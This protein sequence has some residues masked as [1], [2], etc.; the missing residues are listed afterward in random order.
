[1]TF[2]IG[3]F[4]YS[5]QNYV[6]QP[7]G[8]EETAT[9]QGL[10]ARKV[11][12]SVLLSAADWLDLT[13]EY[14]NWR[15]LRIEDPDSKTSLDVGTTIGVSLSANGL[16]WSN[17]PCWFIQ[18]PAGEQVGAYVQ[19][20]VELVDADQALQVAIKEDLLSRSRYYFGTYTLGGVTLNLL[21]P[22]ET[23]QDTPQVS[24]TASGTSYITGA[25]IATRV[26]QLEGDTDSQGWIDIRDW[27]ESTVVLYPSVGDWFPI[28]APSATAEPDIVAGVRVDRYTVSVSLAQVI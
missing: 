22:P 8:Y 10:T 15:D 16:S 24:L 27:Y 14:D 17:V 13:Q 21:K 11:R 6:A 23:Y 12:I 18:A 19:A 20:T 7:F 4:T 3:G 28:T 25:L 26:L 5:G 1:M 9:R 2:A